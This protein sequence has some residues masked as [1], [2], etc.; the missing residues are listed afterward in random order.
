MQKIHY[1][2][3]KNK[4]KKKNPSSFLKRR[5][6]AHKKMVGVLKKWKSLEILLN[7]NLILHLEFR[8]KVR[9]DIY[10]F[11]FIDKQLFKINYVHILVMSRNRS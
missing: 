7:S 3:I 2:D 1:N 4:N 5:L 9:C 11:S 10:F 6:Q 8:A